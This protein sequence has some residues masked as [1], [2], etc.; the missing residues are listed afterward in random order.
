MIIFLQRHALQCFYSFYITEFVS[1]IQGND[2]SY[3]LSVSSYISQKS[4][5]YM[6]VV[7]PKLLSTR[8]RSDVRSESLPPF[9]LVIK[10]FES[11]PRSVADFNARVCLSSTRKRLA[12]IIPDAELLCMA[13]ISHL[14]R[15]QQSLGTE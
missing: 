10:T 6:C 11:F 3:F 14:Q 9:K 7:I 13:I 4:I 5:T 8:F 12:V 2:V 1:F 15:I